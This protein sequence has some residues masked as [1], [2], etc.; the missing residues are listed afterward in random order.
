MF[1]SNAWGIEKYIWTGTAS[2]TWFPLLPDK[3]WNGALTFLSI[4][5]SVLYLNYTSENANNL[6]H[7]VQWP[8]LDV[9]LKPDIAFNQAKEIPLMKNGNRGIISITRNTP[10]MRL[11]RSFFST[12]KEFNNLKATPVSLCCSCS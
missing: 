8:L 5:S 1:I 2:L 9:N 4:V 11:Q 3:M 6:L 12:G 10:S 7:H